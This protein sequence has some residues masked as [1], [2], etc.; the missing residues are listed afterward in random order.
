MRGRSLA[1]QKEKARNGR[2]VE[3]HPD[4]T[5]EIGWSPIFQY[6]KDF[7][8]NGFIPSARCNVAKMPYIHFFSIS[9]WIKLVFG[10]DNV[11]ICVKNF[12]QKSI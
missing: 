7:L 1:T 8:P 6:E 3:F 2:R 10:K 4:H 5:A 11:L 12:L 9:I